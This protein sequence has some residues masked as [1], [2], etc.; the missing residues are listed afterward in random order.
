MFV[1]GG[2]GTGKTFFVNHFLK[3]YAEK[4]QICKQMAEAFFYFRLS[5]ASSLSFQSLVVFLVLLWLR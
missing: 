1:C 3:T 2:H 4:N 5:S